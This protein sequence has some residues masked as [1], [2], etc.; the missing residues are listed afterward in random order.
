MKA[1]PVREHRWLQKLVGEWTY[2]GEADMGGKVS[3]S[4]GTETVRS[5]GDVWVVGEGQGT[6]PGGGPAVSLMTLGYDPQAKRFTGTWIGSVMTYL[7]SYDAGTLDEAANRLTLECDGPG[8]SDAARA[9]GKTSRYR[10]VIEF[11]GDDERVLTASVRNDDGTW[12]T[13]MTTRYR[14]KR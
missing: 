3:K 1:E 10:D 2:E 12:T 9:E 14:R 6:M 11:R 13:F 5:I 7:W 4:A 8:F